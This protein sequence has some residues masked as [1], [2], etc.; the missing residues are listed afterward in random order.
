MATADART[1]LEFAAS[2][3]D[4]P[5][6][7]DA[8]CLLRRGLASAWLS[9]PPSEPTGAV[10]VAS[11]MPGEPMAFGSDPLA[12]WSLLREIPGWRCV[13]APAELAPGLAVVLER[14]LRSPSQLL[15]DIYYVL[16]H[17][18]ARH[19]HPLVRRLTED[20]LPM[21]ERAPEALRLRGFP[22]TTAALVGGVAAGAI[23]DGELVAEM[24]MTTSSEEYADLGG[25]TLEPWRD[26]G[27]GSA[28]AFLVAEELRGR[29]FTPVWSTGE[30][31]GPSRR[32]AGK[33]GFR[34]FGRK[35]YVVVP[36]LREAR[37]YR[38]ERDP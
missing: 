32:V 17:A 20:D 30:D 36:E 15:G 24:A 11:W 31:N 19:G 18:P 13:N 37:G 28:A 10:V 7:L 5:F 6:T 3:P 2:L 33:L 21:V 16:E 4:H 26:R 1:A 34:E 35:S 9:G 25:H 38:P 14:E 8:R 22:S 23:V 29:G 12:I 27:V